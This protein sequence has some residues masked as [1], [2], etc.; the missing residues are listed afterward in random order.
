M[1]TH[2]TR[3]SKARPAALPD[4]GRS[5]KLGRKVHKNSYHTAMTGSCDGESS[6]KI[7]EAL[8]EVLQDISEAA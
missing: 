7:L 3:P 2:R 1:T 5:K 6:R 4:A 8:R